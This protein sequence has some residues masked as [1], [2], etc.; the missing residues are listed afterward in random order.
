VALIV[1][2]AAV[3]HASTRRRLP[4]PIVAACLAALVAVDLVDFARAW[5]PLVP[6][7]LVYP[8]VA[9]IETVRQDRHVFR[10]A[11]WGS[12]L[13]PNTNVVY[14]LQQYRGYDSMNQV[15]YGRLLDRALGSEATL[16]IDRPFQDSTVF[17][18]LNVKYLFTAPG[19]R[20]PDEH[21][22]ERGPGLYEN[23][24]VLPRAL[25]AESATV[26]DAPAALERVVSPSFDPTR[27]VVLERE[28]SPDAQP[29]RRSGDTADRVRF[30]QYRDELVE[31][32]VET[33]GRR[34]LVL[35]DLFYPGW[36]ATVDG[37]ATRVF[38][39]NYAFRG[40]A[41][42]AGRSVVRFEYAPRSFAIG[43][44]LSSLAAALI[45]FC[46]GV[47]RPTPEVE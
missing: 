41:V 9:T 35:T 39:A 40:I 34:V 47:T 1:A 2:T 19:V 16:Y 36:V 20:V 44:V 25:L 28:V 14:G 7:S 6:A 22:V 10:V 13:Q 8:T 27:E 46:L 4:A 38:R 23:R 33:T 45:A 31:L 21:F 42:P 5:R 30:T 37:A 26:L 24:R 32:D 11:G 3:A 17:D 18:L 43:A 29:E 12:A 15:R